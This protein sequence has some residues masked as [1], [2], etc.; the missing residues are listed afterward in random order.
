MHSIIIIIIT[1]L[2][3]T[4]LVDNIYEHRTSATESD[5]LM[6][7]YKHNLIISVASDVTINYEIYN[8]SL[9]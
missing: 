3:F 5:V 6:I 7:G 4:V 9:Q 2:W 8:Q 1:H